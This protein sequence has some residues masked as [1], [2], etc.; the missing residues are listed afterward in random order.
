MKRITTFIYKGQSFEI[1]S[2][3]KGDLINHGMNERNLIGIIVAIPQTNINR[4]GT[5]KRTLCL[6]EMFGDFN[7]N[8]INYVMARIREHIDL[9]KWKRENNINLDTPDGVKKLYEYLSSRG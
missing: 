3:Q 5:M 6:G 8:D 1:C 2:T 7:H 4:D 9:M